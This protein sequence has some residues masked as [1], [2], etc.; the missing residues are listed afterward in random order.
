MKFPGVAFFSATV[1]QRKMT[2][3][4]ACVPG[5]ARE[6]LLRKAGPPWEMEG[7]SFLFLAYPAD[8]P[9]V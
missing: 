3:P 6:W 2:L 9:W 5:V 4:P 7:R 1:A 8:K